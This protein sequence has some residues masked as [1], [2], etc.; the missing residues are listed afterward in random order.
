MGTTPSLD[1]MLISHSSVVVSLLDG[2]HTKCTNMTSLMFSKPMNSSPRPLTSSSTASCSKP[3]EKNVS[4]PNNSQAESMQLHSEPF[5][6]TQDHPD[7]RN[8][9][10]PSLK[11][12]VFQTKPS[13]L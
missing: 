2:T 4:T 10:V 12:S 7:Q 1:S 8:D 13:R 6:T 5:Q 9:D 11:L 3:T